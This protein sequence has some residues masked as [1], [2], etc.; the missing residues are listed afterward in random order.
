VIIYI[1]TIHHRHYFLFLT[2]IGTLH[3][4][5]LTFVVVGGG[6]GI[7]RTISPSQLFD[8]KTTLIMCIYPTL[9]FVLVI[10]K[11]FCKTY[12]DSTKNNEPFDFVFGW[13]TGHVGTTTLST[14]QTYN[15]PGHIKFIFEEGSQR[16]ESYRKHVRKD[17]EHFV[18][19]KYLPHMLTKRGNYTTLMDLGK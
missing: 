6:G 15:N 7:I 4:K 13:S 9:L 12:L 1:D 10:S 18:K 2:T 8:Y 11:V 17:E 3:S 14:K 19:E 5:Q 16:I